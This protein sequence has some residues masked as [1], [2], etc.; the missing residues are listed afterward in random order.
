MGR[1]KSKRT[2]AGRQP[3]SNQQWRICFRWIDD[4]AE[5]V[6]IVDYHS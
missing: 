4:G 2:S 1:R 5:D 3:G 6:E